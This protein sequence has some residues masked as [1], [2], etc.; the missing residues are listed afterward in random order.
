MISLILGFL[1][2]KYKLENKYNAIGNQNNPP[3]YLLM[4]SRPVLVRFEVKPVLYW[5][6]WSG[7]F[8]NIES[9]NVYLALG[10][11]LSS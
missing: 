7:N 10:V 11:A 3:M 2:H 5:L 9:M 1:S 4:S 8:F 6:I